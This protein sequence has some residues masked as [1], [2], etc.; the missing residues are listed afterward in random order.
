[1]RPCFSGVRLRACFIDP[2]RLSDHAGLLDTRCIPPAR[3]ALALS[4]ALACVA[5][6]A[7][8]GALGGAFGLLG[9]CALRGALARVALALARRGL[10]VALALGAALALLAAARA[11]R[12][13][14]RLHE[15]QRM[16]CKATQPL[17]MR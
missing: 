14:V 10:G 4:A 3:L 11:A 15:S 16:S 13:L 12:L 7:S 1:M 17:N 6:R 8:L 9:A 5:A 2:L